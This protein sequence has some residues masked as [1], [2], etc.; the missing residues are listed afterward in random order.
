[1]SKDS[2]KQ[3]SVKV[4]CL[5]QHNGKLLVNKGYD[6]VKKQVFYRL[7]GGKVEFG[8]RMQDTIRRE[9]KEE[10]NS[11][12]TNTIFITAKEEIF[13]YEGE[14]GHEINFLFN[15]TLA[16]KELFEK[17]IIPN[18]DSEEFPAIWIPVEDVLKEKVIIYPSF[19]Y[20]KILYK[21]K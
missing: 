11:G 4:M 1:M 12:V 8:E 21:D 18:P 19:N 9:I 17:E 2:A 10:L 6:K 20:K 7:V 16:N 15:V 14:T 13:T 3:I 5:I